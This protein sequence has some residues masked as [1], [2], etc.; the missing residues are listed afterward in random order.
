MIPPFGYRGLMVGSNKNIHKEN[1][2]SLG[3]SSAEDI[4][5]KKGKIQESNKQ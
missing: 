3:S 2:Q 1:K 4:R 5:D